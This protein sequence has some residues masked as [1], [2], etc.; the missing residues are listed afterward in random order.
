[1]KFENTKKSS[2]YGL[3]GFI[4]FLII[5]FFSATPFELLDI[6]VSTIPRGLALIYSALLNLLVLITIIILFKSYLKDAWKDFK[7]NK[8]TYFKKYFKYWFL[9]IIGILVSNTIITIISGNNL[10][11]NEEEVRNLLTSNPIYMWISAVLIAPFLEEFV[12]RLSFRNIFS[13]KWM[14][15]ILSGITFGAFHLIGNVE[16]LTDLLY[17][18]PYSIPGCIFAYIL[19]DSKNIFNTVFLHMFHNGILTSLE[20]LLLLLGVSIV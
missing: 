9:I 2:L 5:F 16:G 13:S 19:Y 12:F 1:M 3:L 15:I 7:E 8:N 17:I 14:F 18:I 11:G 6:D 4:L 20:I 10:S